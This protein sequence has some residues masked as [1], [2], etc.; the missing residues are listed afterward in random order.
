MIEVV[1]FLE[2]WRSWGPKE[3]PLWGNRPNSQIYTARELYLMMG[4][5]YQSQYVRLL[6]LNGQVE[7]ESGPLEPG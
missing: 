6:P 5:C 2:T 7:S 4:D 1:H 3:R